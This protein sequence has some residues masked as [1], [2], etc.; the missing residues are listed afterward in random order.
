MTNSLRQEIRKLLKEV[1]DSGWGLDE[2]ARPQSEYDEVLNK[3][4]DAISKAFLGKL[5]KKTFEEIKELVKKIK[6]E[7]GECDK[8][9]IADR[10]DGYNQSQDAIRLFLFLV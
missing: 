2:Y 10:A 3:A 5:K 4:L 7:K 8:Y 9:A 6:S 1:L